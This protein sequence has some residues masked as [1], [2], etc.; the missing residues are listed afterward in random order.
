MLNVLRTWASLLTAAFKVRLV[1]TP[2]PV[3]TELGVASLSVGVTR[4]PVP[5]WCST[6]ETWR[7]TWL[8]SFW[9]KTSTWAKSMSSILK[10]PP[11]RHMTTPGGLCIM[12]VWW[13]SCPE[14]TPAPR[15]LPWSPRKAVPAA[16]AVR[17][18]AAS[19][20]APSRRSC[21]SSRRPCCACSAARARSTRPSAPAATPC[22]ARA[23]P[24][25]SRWGSTGSRWGGPPGSRWGGRLVPG[26]GGRLAP[27]EG[28]PPSS[29]WGSLPGYGWG[30]RL[31]PGEGPQG[32]RWGAAA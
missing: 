18:S 12:R 7:A 17:A 24:P 13:T 8:L 9:M 28:G 32:S 26:E 29:R 16:A 14:A 19:R 30:G 15:T 25:S 6:A 5:S 4:W 3:S 20:P 2:R 10:E 23:V 21:A 31:A 11:R 22:A 1:G 27:G